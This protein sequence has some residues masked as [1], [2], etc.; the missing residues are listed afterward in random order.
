MYIRVHLNKVLQK[1]S[2][3]NT[4]SSV[5]KH[6]LGIFGMMGWDFWSFAI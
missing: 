4:S 5:A 6:K 1:F 2:T 3:A